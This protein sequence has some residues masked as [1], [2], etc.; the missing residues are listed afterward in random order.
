M[1]GNRSARIL[2]PYQARDKW[3]LV[4]IDGASRKSMIFGSIEQAEAARDSIGEH[5]QQHV[6]LI[7]EALTQ[8]ADEKR[9]SGC[10]PLSVQAV[11]DRLSSFLPIERPMASLS[12]DEAQQIYDALGERFATATHHAALKR[13]KE[14][15]RWAIARNL[16]SVNP[17][18]S[19]KPVGKPRRGKLQLSLD[20]ARKLSRALLSDAEQGDELSLAL[21]LQVLL[22]LRTSEV[23]LR[24]VRDVDDGGRLLII[25]SGKTENARRR[26][27]VPDVLTAL[28]R[29]LVTNKAPDAFLFGGPSGHRQAWMWKGLRRYCEKLGL[30]TVCPHSLRGLHSS[31]AVEAGRTSQEVAAQLGHGSFGVTALHYVRPGAIENTRIRKVSGLLAQDREPAMESASPMKSALLS[32]LASL[33][34]ADLAKLLSVLPTLTDK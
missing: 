20:E 24:R 7:G 26:L 29:G 18:A 32:Q 31:L 15:Y 33:S 25:A 9:R 3:R 21:L 19:I 14:L 16:V 30:P 23:L 4:I 34:E 12:T 27:E 1:R 13:A 10:K 11:F 5:L 6:I 22:G 28:L 8:F 17:F 2:G